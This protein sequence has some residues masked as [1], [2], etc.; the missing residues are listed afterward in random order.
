MVQKTYNIVQISVQS[1]KF[2]RDIEV[3][4]QSNSG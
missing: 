4:P 3:Y 2:G 1:K